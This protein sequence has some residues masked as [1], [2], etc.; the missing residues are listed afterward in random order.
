[1]E[2]VLKQRK[3]EE[4]KLM[5]ISKF[6][7]L[8]YETG[9]PLEDIVLDSLNLIGFNANRIQVEDKEHDVVMVSE[10]GRALAEIEEIRKFAQK[11]LDYERGKC[12]TSSRLETLAL[13]ITAC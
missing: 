8:L 2:E 13:E 4:E 1:M 10:E 7:T 3:A 6:K 11:N 12:L 5:N 9:I